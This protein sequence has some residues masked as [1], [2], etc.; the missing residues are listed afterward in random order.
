MGCGETLAD[1]SYGRKAEADP[2]SRGG[3]HR[4]EGGGGR[5]AGETDDDLREIGS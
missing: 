5:Q 3:S 1:G 4:D 2:E